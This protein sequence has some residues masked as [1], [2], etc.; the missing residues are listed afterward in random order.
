MKEILDFNLCKRLY[1]VGIIV[2]TEYKYIW[3]MS[4]EYILWQWHIRLSYHF[5]LPDIP[6]LTIVDWLDLIFENISNVILDRISHNNWE[7]EI[8]KLWD[9]KRFLWTFKDCVEQ[10]ITYLLD[11]NLLWQTK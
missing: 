2:E 10:A 6:A 4:W 1:E 5:P 3:S 11:N 9:W 8:M 7:I